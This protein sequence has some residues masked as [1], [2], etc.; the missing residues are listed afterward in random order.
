[1]SS[2]KIKFV[3]C[4]ILSFIPTKATPNSAGFDL[5]SPDSLI[6][7]PS[8]TCIIC[9]GLKIE[10]PPKCYGRIAPRSSLSLKSISIGGGIIDNDYRGEIKIILHNLSNVNNY[11]IN[12]GDKIAQLI[13]EKYVNIEFLEVLSLSTTLRNENGFGSSD[14][15]ISIENI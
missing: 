11:C 8:S 9:T 15:A 3:R 2:E 4:N 12:R 10:L 14:I 13:C 5:Y 1:M 6:L 7:L